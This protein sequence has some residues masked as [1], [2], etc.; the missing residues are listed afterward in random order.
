M[1][2]TDLKV[3]LATMEPVLF[4]EP[5]GVEALAELSHA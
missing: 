4:A 2:E 3:L 5:Y 1:G